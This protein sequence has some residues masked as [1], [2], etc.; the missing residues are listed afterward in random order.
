MSVENVKAYFRE[1][2]LP[3]EIM[4]FEASTETVERAAEALG[5][6][7][8]LIAKSLA[9]KVKDRPVLVVT[10]GDA[11]IDNQKF[12]KQFQAKAKMMSPDEVLEITGHPVGGVCPFG[13]KQPMEIYLDESLRSFDRVYPAGGSRNTCIEISP[14]ELA[15]LTKAPWVDVCK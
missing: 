12:K 10:K 7:P 3:Y 5:V 6:A 13:L 14:E 11:R 8:A 2:D 1:N 15:R 9:F 4:E